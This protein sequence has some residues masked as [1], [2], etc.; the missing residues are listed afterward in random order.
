MRTTAL[1]HL[2]G[3]MQP[4]SGTGGSRARWAHATVKVPS[5]VAKVGRPFG[6]LTVGALAAGGGAK[7]STW[8][9]AWVCCAS[10]ASTRNLRQGGR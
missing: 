2:T 10:S 7:R 6:K 5:A 9:R 3:L 1:I 8:A 4:T